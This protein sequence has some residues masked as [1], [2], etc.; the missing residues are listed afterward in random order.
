[1]AYDPG[2]RPSAFPGM[3]NPS[4]TPISI[5]PPQTGR[6]GGTVRRASAPRPKPKVSSNSR[7]NYARPVAPPATKPGP[8]MDINAFLN[9]DAGYQ[10][11]LREFAKTLSDFTGDVTRR[12]GDMTTNFG[13]SKKALED[14]RVLDLKAI[15]DDFGARG[16]L[17]SGLYADARGNYEQEYGNRLTDLTNQ[18]NQALAALLSEEGQFKASQDLKQQAAREDAIRRRAELMGV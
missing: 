10:Q 4:S 12:R 2:S 1:M 5:P 6:A 11:Q 16:L 17:R 3:T 15:E 9:Q 8:V 7:G 14:Q 13:T 18:Q